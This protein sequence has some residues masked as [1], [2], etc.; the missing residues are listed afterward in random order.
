[1]YIMLNNE[2]LHLLGYIWPMD[3][4]L[5]PNAPAGPVC[6]ECWSWWVWYLSSGST[7]S[8]LFGHQAGPGTRVRS[9]TFWYGDVAALLIV[10]AA[11]AFLMPRSGGA[12]PEVSTV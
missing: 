2:D 12:A 6:Q 5:V 10:A 9:E 7:H 8:P 4:S 3:S 11:L 1:M